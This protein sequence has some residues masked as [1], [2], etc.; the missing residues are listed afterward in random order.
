MTNIQTHK[1]KSRVINV[2]V[3]QACYDK[4]LESALSKSKKTK[5]VVRISEIVRDAINNTI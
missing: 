3:D 5:R 1:S 2:R 4:L